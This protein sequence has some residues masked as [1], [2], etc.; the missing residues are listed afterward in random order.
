MKNP[1]LW[2]RMKRFDAECARDEYTALKRLGKKRF[3]QLFRVVFNGRTKLIVPKDTSKVTLADLE[4]MWPTDIR[5]NQVFPRK[6]GGPVWYVS[7]S[8]DEPKP[9]PPKEKTTG[10]RP[11]RRKYDIRPAPKRVRLRAYEKKYGKEAL[12]IYLELFKDVYCDSC[13]GLRSHQWCDMHSCE[14]VLDA[15]NYTLSGKK[16]E[17]KGD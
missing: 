12:R 9:P 11:R 4:K 14:N 7:G 15:I 1:F 17:R 5:M 2:K 13:S 3:N 16:S 10:R 8:L 6:N